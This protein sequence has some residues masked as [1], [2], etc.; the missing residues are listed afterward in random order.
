[1]LDLR[2][3]GLADEDA[4]RASP[5]GSGRMLQT[6]V[7]HMLASRRGIAGSVVDVVCLKGTGKWGMGNGAVLLHVVGPASKRT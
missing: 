3:R 7:E 1:M 2:D 6:V 4:G 5:P